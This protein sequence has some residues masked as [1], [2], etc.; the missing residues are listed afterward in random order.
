MSKHMI[1]AEVA[2]QSHITEDI[3]SLVLKA[4]EIAEEAVPGQFV[5]IYGII[6]FEILSVQPF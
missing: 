2:S 1:T 6:L 4:H 3:Y 5:I